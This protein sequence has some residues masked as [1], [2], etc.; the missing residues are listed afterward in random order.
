MNREV[1][2]VQQHTVEPCATGQ[3]GMKGAKSDLLVT[4]E[5]YKGAFLGLIYGMY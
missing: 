2:K 5:A 4:M 1:R 3:E